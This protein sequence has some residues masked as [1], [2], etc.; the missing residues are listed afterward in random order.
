MY[1]VLYIYIYI[2][3]CVVIYWGNLHKCVMETHIVPQML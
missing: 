3:L 2:V 1:V